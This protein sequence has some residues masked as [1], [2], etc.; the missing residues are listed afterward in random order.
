MA[1]FIWFFVGIIVVLLLLANYARDILKN[2]D[3]M[4]P[5]W[6][7]YVLVIGLLVFVTAMIYSVA[8]PPR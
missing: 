7:F 4:M 1:S 6:L 5:R 3:I 2:I 8:N